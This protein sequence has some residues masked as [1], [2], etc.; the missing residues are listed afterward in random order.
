MSKSTSDKKTE[1][2]TE[3]VP[4]N[5]IK[6]IITEDLKNNKNDGRV[7]T[8]F[9]PE[10]NGYLHIGHAKSICLNFGIASAYP[11]GTCNL[12]FDDTNPT[13]EDIEYVDSIMEDVHWLGFDWED[14]QHYASDYFEKLHDFAIQLIEAG[15]AY[16]CD[17]NEAETREYK[18]NYYTKAKPSPYR[19]RSVEENLDLFKRMREGEFKDGEKSLKA[20]V[21]LESANMNMR[22]PVIY[23]IKHA[24]HHRTGDK[25]CIYPMY[26]FAHGLSDAIEGI[27][28]SICTLEFQDHRPLYN[29]FLEVLKIE[30][31][32]QQ[33]EFARLNLTYTVMSKRKL[34]ELVEE[35]FVSGWNDPRMPTIS[36]L[37][38]R[39]FT[40]KS[41]RNF[42]EKIGVAKADSM[43][44]VALLEHCVR[45]DL[46][47]SAPRVMGVLNPLKLVIDNFP[48]DEVMELDCPYHPEAPA[49]GS[50]MVPFTKVLYVEKDD[51]KEE[52]PRKWF[53]L[54]PG[55]EVRLRYACLV[56]CNEVIKDENGEVVELHCTWDPESK[57]GTSPDGRKVKGTIH[58]VSSEHAIDAEVRLYD[59][60]FNVSNPMGNSDEKTFKDHINPDSLT[61]L[62]NCKLE[63]S[64]KGLKPEEH[65]QLERLG[66]FN[67]D[68]VDS[69]EGNIVLNRTVPL[70]DS[71]AR[72][73][74][75]NKKKSN[76]QPKQKQ[77]KKE[78][79]KQIKIDDFAKIDLRVGLVKEA[80][81]VE[82]A[83]RLLRLIVDVGEEKPR[84]IFSGIRSSYPEPEIL[85]GTYV[86]VVA[87]LK[88]RK[89]KFG[90]SEG[91][92]LSAGNDPK[93]FRVATFA[94]DC[95]PG[96][97]IS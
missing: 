34:L 26:D 28:H 13:K 94:D 89:M 2:A 51:F 66:Y 64:L 91:M 43:V 90:I 40:S 86:I 14:R 3:S 53:R 36:G 82:G 42:A 45:E 58:W 7:A 46:N 29:W 97:E 41:I 44:D 67:V 5:F 8:R 56:T 72:I 84:Q 9:P 30:Q 17:L 68:N 62:K 47:D 83:D 75:A 4:S 37:R 18:G 80:S 85:I 60:L 74:K 33:I 31:P 81:F 79:D 73:E 55:K 93:K 27:T 78:D 24:N 76:K 16:V 1:V 38:R 92:V 25:W 32:P 20:I 23:R 12:R 96:D 88:P 35:K 39:G 50:R 52:A 48:E 54:A 21:D 22:D 71:W 11:N 65:Y 49:M 69:S 87:N 61:I 95:K 15:K 63:P 70:R 57:G 77:A 19:T 6:E 59:R 10:P